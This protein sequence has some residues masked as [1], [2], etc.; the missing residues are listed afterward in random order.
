MFWNYLKVAWRNLTRHKVFSFINITGLTG[1]VAICLILFVHVKDELSYDR[2]HEKVDRIYRLQYNIMDFN[3]ARTPPPLAPRLA[4]YFPE[5]EMAGR[6]FSRS[7]SVG[8]P[9]NGEVERPF[10]EER[11]FFADSTL[12]DIF[13]FDIVMGNAENPLD[14]PFSVIINEEMAK[15]YFGSENPIG[16]Y[17]V[18][19]GEHTFKV[20]AVAKDMPSNSHWHFNLI[21]PYDNMFDV[22]G[23]TAFGSLR[24]NLNNNWMASHSFTYVLLRTN[25]NPQHVNAKFPD[26]IKEH[27]PENQQKG[28][29]FILQS[30]ADIRL[31]GNLG[32][33]IEPVGDITQVYLFI[34]IGLMTLLIACI[35]FINLSTARAL[36]RIKEVGMRKVMGAWRGQLVAQ[37]LGESLLV[38]LLAFVLAFGLATYLLPEVNTLTGKEVQ[39]DDFL[40]PIT[41]LAFFALF[42]LT[43]FLAGLYPAIYIARFQPVAVLKGRIV[44]TNPGGLSL[45]KVLVIF[46]FTI[47]VVLITG[48]VVIRDQVGLFRNRPLG[49]QKDAIITVP[50]FSNNFNNAF[51]GMTAELRQKLNTLE[52]EIS[53]NP[54]VNSSTLSSNVPGLGAVRRNVIPDGFTAEDAIINPSL[55]VDYDFLENFELELLA[56]RDFSRSFGTDHTNAFIVNEEALARYE[57]GSPEEALG[58]SLNLEG[59]EGQVVGVIRDFHF[60]SLRGAIDPLILDVNAG[61]F[62]TMSVNV[63]ATELPNTIDFLQSKWN[64]FF[65]DK[66][67]EYRFLDEQIDS[68][69]EG[70]EN[71][72]KIITYFAFLAILIS[73]LGSYGL[74][75]FLAEQKMKEIGI[76]KVL[77]ASVPSI[78]TLLAK[79]FA[80]LLGISF[81]ISVP[82]AYFLLDTWLSDFVFRVELGPGMFLLG[83]LITFGIVALTISYQSIKAAFVNPARILRSE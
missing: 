50:L 26:F 53:A 22:E 41:L 36:Q 12:L 2:F 69:Y 8:V 68:T 75:M 11:V 71:L 32:A 13:T 49:F 18:L 55:S 14:E 80:V 38:C 23:E 82:L 77:G 16:K 42:L 30:V 19:E 48:T 47:A 81:V 31:R 10:E 76:R 29:E 28:Q 34:G 65:P 33:E 3:I 83:G 64:E 25:Q 43:G 56:G 9:E 15:K 60:E 5:V 79:G 46:Q 52:D 73:C 66:A 67:F 1:G 72:G 45:R 61:L 4:E 27:M 54:R 44:D 70:E 40:A 17:L 62:T 58:K 6:L 51:G 39:V 35:N 78:I 57:W 24:N 7:A 37:L 21:M 74:I 59:K 63:Q 20:V